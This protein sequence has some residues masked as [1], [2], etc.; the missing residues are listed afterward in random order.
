MA[1]NVA[2]YMAMNV[3]II[4]YKILL[5]SETNVLNKWNLIKL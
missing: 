1:M 2:Q 3:V 5:V 4:I